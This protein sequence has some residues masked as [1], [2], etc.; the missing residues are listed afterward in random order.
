MKK[1]TLII[2][3]I[4]AFLFNS[5]KKSKDPQPE[6]TN[7]VPAQT[8]PA[9]VKSQPLR[10]LVSTAEGKLLGGYMYK[11]DSKG[12]V[13]SLESLDSTGNINS[14]YNTKYEYNSDGTLSKVNDIN[15]SGSDNYIFEYNSGLVSKIIKTTGSNTIT[16]K[17]YYTGGNLNII[18]SIESIGS[19][20]YRDSISFE[21]YNAAGRPA[22]SKHFFTTYVM[23]SYYTYDN[24]SNLTSTQTSDDLHNNIKSL[25]FEYSYTGDVLPEAFSM[26]SYFGIETDPNLSSKNKDTNFISQTKFYG[27]CIRELSTL[28]YE[29]NTSLIKKDGSGRIIS[30]KSQTISHKVTCSP[31]DGDSGYIYT[32]EY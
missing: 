29:T 32:F 20:K 17:Y 21:N 11:Y 14:K 13:I 27:N 10:Y 9:Q 26:L 5:C 12:R 6:I 30:F 31:Q 16:Y 3:T 7:P 19:M 8:S 24:N 15:Q 4:S 25:K 28:I 23:T 1:A 18:S 22:L 2:L